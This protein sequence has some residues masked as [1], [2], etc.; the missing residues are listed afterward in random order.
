MYNDTL[1]FIYISHIVFTDLGCYFLYN[2]CISSSSY[3]KY[4][5]NMGQNSNIP[6]YIHNLCK[7]NLWMIIS[8][9]RIQSIFLA[10]RVLHAT[11]RFHEKYKEKQ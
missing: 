7:H 8:A 9:S 4:T 3:R 1:S 5:I 6:K 10:P 11:S 2:N